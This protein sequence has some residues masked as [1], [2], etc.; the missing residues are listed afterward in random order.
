MSLNEVFFYDP[1]DY[2]VGLTDKWTPNPFEEGEWYK[3]LIVN[4]DNGLMELRITCD[5]E[6]SDAMDADDRRN[7]YF[8]IGDYIYNYR[9]MD[10]VN[11]ELKG[12]V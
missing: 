1:Y 2:G 11:D 10:Q 4:D 9:H 6:Q 7:C 5:P 8:E 12:C 3:L